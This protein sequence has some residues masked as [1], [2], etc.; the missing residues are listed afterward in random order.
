MVIF[1]FLPKRKKIKKF[2]KLACNINDKEYYVVHI[3]QA[4]DHRLILST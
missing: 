3:K 2:N 1:H 4:L